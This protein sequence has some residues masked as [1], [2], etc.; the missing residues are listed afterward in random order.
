MI[1]D[2]ER[3]PCNERR[4]ILNSLIRV[5]FHALHSRIIG[6][7]LE[8]LDRTTFSHEENQI[9]PNETE[10]PFQ[11]RTTF[12]HEENQINRVKGVV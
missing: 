7:I 9:Q 2:A 5:Y 12:L 3:C 10:R 6:L 11:D 1:S 4:L 8:P